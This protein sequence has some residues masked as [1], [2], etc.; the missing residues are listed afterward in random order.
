MVKYCCKSGVISVSCSV[1]KGN[2]CDVSVHKKVLFLTKVK[3]KE[4]KI[5]GRMIKKLV[6]Y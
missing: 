3:K 1:I 2:K 6:I 5:T 4:K